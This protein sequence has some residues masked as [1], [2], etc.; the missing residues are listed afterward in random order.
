[1]SNSVPSNWTW[2]V[3]GTWHCPTRDPSVPLSLLRYADL[4]LKS[5]FVVR[6]DWLFLSP[7]L[8]FIGVVSLPLPSPFYKSVCMS[9]SSPRHRSLRNPPFRLLSLS[10]RRPNRRSGHFFD[11]IF[12][13]FWIFTRTA[14]RSVSPFLMEFRFCLFSWAAGFWDKAYT[15]SRWRGAV[16]VSRCGCSRSC[17]AG[18]PSRRSWNW[19]PSPWVLPESNPLFTLIVSCTLRLV[20]V[21]C[22]WR[23]VIVIWKILRGRVMN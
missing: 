21:S 15:E 9:A 4:S 8:G 22:L 18:G 13:F 3:D 20:V 10:R 12:F 1:M 14:L 16:L 19:R 7:S 23:S 6:R 17:Q 5:S 2:H 11:S